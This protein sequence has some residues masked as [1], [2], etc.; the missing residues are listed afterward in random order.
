MSSGD[1]TKLN[2]I[3]TGANKYTHP[4]S[5]GNK[6]IP[7]G[8]S[9][10]QILR[11][12]SDGTAVWGA[13]NNTTYS[14]MSGATASKAGTSGLV[15]APAAGKQ[16]QFLRGDG[17][18]A[19]PT[20]AAKLV[21]GRTIQTNLGSTSTA[22]FDGTANITPGVTGILPAA[23]GGTGNTTGEASSVGS[24]QLTD[25]DLNS[26]S[27]VPGHL[28]YAMG[29]NSV[30]NK[31]SGI[32]NFGMFVMQTANGWYTQVLYGSDDDIW[33][34]RWASSN[35]TSW[36]KIYSTGNKPTVSDIGAAAADHSHEN[37]T[38]STSGMMS[39]SD[40][41]KLDGYPDDLSDYSTT[42]EMNNAIEMAVYGAIHSFY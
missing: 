16:G 29:G 19:T 24:I 25:E 21:T 27:S 12:G 23:N 13:D 6:H 14:P 3:A 36:V 34:R 9:S 4:T 40:K 22:N 11:W 39:A 42:D 38:I 2:G 31:P 37:A 7:S 8:G 17:T 41:E 15:P 35:W 5:S 10:G 1:K 28:Y 20:E 32:D 33:T 30:T 18:W 26:L